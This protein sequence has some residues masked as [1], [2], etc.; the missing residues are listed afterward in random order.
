MDFIT[1][2]PIPTIV[3]IGALFLVTIVAI[4]ILVIDFI[5]LIKNNDS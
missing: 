2:L 5:K 3:G 1:Q 4:G